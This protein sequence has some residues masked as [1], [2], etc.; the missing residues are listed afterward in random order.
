MMLTQ[1]FITPSLAALAAGLLR[2]FSVCFAQVRPLAA[3][4][5]LAHI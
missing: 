1:L 2:A 4:A 3:P 5:A